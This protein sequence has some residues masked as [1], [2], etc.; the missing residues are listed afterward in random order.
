MV[1][2]PGREVHTKSIETFWSI[3]KLGIIG[4]CHN[5]SVEYLPNYLEEFSYRFPHTTNEKRVGLWKAVLANALA[6]R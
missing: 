4:S 6:R 3:L 5:V 2:T 1:T